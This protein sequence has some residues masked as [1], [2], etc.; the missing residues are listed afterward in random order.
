MRSDSR[1]ARHVEQKPVVAFTIDNYSDDWTETKGVQGTAECE[2]VLN[3]ME[4]A[5][6]AN[7]FGKKFPTL[8]PGQSTMG[9]SFFR[10]TPMQLEFIDNSRERG[11][12]R[13]EFGAPFHS[14]VVFDVLSELP[15]Q[16]VSTIAAELTEARYSAGE[17]IARQGAPADKFFI[18]VEGE[19][20]L[21]Q[22]DDGPADPI[23]VL[24]PGRFFGEVAILRDEARSATVRATA[25]TTLLT[26]D[27]ETFRRIV[28]D[29]LGTTE[30]FDRVLQRRLE[31]SGARA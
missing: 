15:L 9:I 22:E 20:E 12:R 19:V 14:D 29:S 31:G 8:S 17:V 21:V 27:R 5:R 28:A 11:K 6:I 24:G 1:T 23:E 2:V 4:I 16:D 26:M 10:V 7:E 3:G 13:E 18:V 30:D 25:P